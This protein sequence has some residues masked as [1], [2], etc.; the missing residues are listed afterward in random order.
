MKRLKYFC[1]L[2]IYLI[3]L[4][5]PHLLQFSDVHFRAM[6]PFFFLEKGSVMTEVRKAGTLYF[7][8]C[9]EVLSVA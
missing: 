4:C 2:S 9:E 1:F 5:C 3:L 6:F 7:W 8:L